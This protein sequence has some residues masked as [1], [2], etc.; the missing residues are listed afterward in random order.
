M[1]QFPEKIRNR[2]WL[3]RNLRKYCS[4]GLLFML[5]PVDIISS[6]HVRCSWIS[7]RVC[8]KAPSAQD[9]LGNIRSRFQFPPWTILKFQYL[10]RCLYERAAAMLI[11]T[12]QSLFWS[13]FNILPV[14]I[15]LMISCSLIYPCYFKLFYSDFLFSIL[16]G[17]ANLPEDIQMH[18]CKHG[19]PY[20]D[21]TSYS[22]LVLLKG[23]QLLVHCLINTFHLTNV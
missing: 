11:Y 8:F 20:T 14:T 10:S 13:H 4:T 6:A 22:P 23:H 19:L 9:V 7:T 3:E 12:L 17:N 5:K 16:E 1:Y 2:V 21:Y 15:V 18:V